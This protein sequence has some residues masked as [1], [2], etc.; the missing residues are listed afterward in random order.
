MASR[1]LAKSESD[2]E[3]GGAL[4][5]RKEVVAKARKGKTEGKRNDDAGREAAAT[6]SLCLYC[7][8]R[9]RY[10]SLAHHLRLTAS[11]VG[12]YVPDGR[13]AEAPYAAV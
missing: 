3:E 1:E 4:G 12:G 7:N 11:F 6:K 10:P 5:G 13:G 9:C 2:G 8:S